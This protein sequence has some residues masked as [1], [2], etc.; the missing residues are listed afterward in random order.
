MAPNTN[1]NGVDALAADAC[2]SDVVSRIYLIRH[3]DRFD[4]A[5]PSWLDAAKEH[6][7]LVTDPPLSALGHRQARETA[8]QLRRIT[9]TDVA[10]KS[11]HVDQILVSPYLRVIQTAC[12]ASDALGLPLHV[13]HGLAEAHATPG[14][15]LPSPAARFASFPQVA[16]N[17]AS[18]LDVVPTPGH[19]CAKTGLP[20]EA[21]AGDYCR[22]MAR[23][24]PLLARAYHGKTVVLFSHA[25]SVALVAALLRRSLRKMKFA[26]CGIYHLERT[27]LGPWRLLRSGESNEEYVEENSPTTYPWGFAEKYFDEGGQGNYSGSAEGIGLDYFVPEEA[28]L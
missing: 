6:G 22:R 10:G 23:F 5:N 20:C 17:Y 21:F 14:G 7:A 24:A 13:E 4:Y 15:A 3:G 18:L 27:N 9:K 28:K 25:A 19:V 12:P 26:P 8:E 2:G 11:H 1:T 16:P